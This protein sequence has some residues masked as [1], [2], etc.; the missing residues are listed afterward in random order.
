MM[1][2]LVVTNHSSQLPLSFV[3]KFES[4]RFVD[5]LLGIGAAGGGASN[6]SEG[7]KL[8]AR[9]ADMRKIRDNAAKVAKA[10]TK[11]EPPKSIMSMPFM[12]GGSSDLTYESMG[13]EPTLLTA[14]TTKRG[15]GTGGRPMTSKSSKKRKKR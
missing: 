14:T 15:V 2:L 1:F 3:V 6:I 10:A 7:K 11:P 5:G 13:D 12:G 9:L 4:E 8:E